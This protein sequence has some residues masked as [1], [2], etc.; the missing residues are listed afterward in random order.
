VE[1]GNW[2]RRV[3]HPDE[4]Q[5]AQQVFE[6]LQG[7]ILARRERA[8]AI[9]RGEEDLASVSDVMSLADC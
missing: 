4:A 3:V 1:I 8:A 7:G 6:S 9:L 2:I 5:T